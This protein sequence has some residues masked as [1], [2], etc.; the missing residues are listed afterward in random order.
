MSY[1]LALQGD[2]VEMRPAPDVVLQAGDMLLL[3]V[4][5]GFAK[6][7]ATDPAFDFLLD[8]P[9]SY[10]PK[11]KLMW[12]AIILTAVMIILQVGPKH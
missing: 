2:L 1:S 10:P 5:E 7:N 3:G 6:R 4:S 8:V 9:K 12:P 11:T